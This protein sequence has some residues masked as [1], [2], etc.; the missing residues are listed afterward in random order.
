MS[1]LNIYTDGGSRGNPGPAACAYV[2]QD[3]QGQILYQDSKYLGLVTNNV[4]EYQGLK[5]S[6]TYL[7]AHQEL[8]KDF[9]SYSFHLDSELVVRQMIGQYKVKDQTLLGYHLEVKKLL[10]ALVLPFEFVHVP[11]SSN[12]NADALL[13]LELDNQKT[14]I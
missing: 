4:A 1:K 14:K 12:Q 13:N 9:D 7:I 5:T 8:Y 3:D 6:L 2:I 11:R 10:S